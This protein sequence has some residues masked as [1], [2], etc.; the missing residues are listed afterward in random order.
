MPV[1]KIKVSNAFDNH[2]V[3]FFFKKD[4]GLIEIIEK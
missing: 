4:I 2:K 1:S 3:C